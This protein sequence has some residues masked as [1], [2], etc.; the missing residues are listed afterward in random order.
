MI[1]HTGGGISRHEFRISDLEKKIGRVENRW[2]SLV[3][4]GAVEQREV[5]DV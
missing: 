2:H 3:V 5:D 1:Y 4:D